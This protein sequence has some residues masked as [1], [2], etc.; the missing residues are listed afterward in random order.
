MTIQKQRLG[1]IIVINV[2]GEMNL[3][4]QKDLYQ[5]LKQLIAKGNYFIILNMEDVIFMSQYMLLVIAAIYNMLKAKDGFLKVAGVKNTARDLFD[6][7]NLNKMVDVFDSVD[8]ALGSCI[9]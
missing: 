7:S 4:T 1:K 9:E 3:V 8:D 5:K 2:K 6:T